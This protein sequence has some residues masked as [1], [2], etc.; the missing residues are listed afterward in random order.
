MTSLWGMWA[1]WLGLSNKARSKTNNKREIMSYK[2]ICFSLAPAMH[3][4][5][6]ISEA[7]SATHPGTG[8][9]W[10][11]SHAGHQS[12]SGGVLRPTAT[13]E[14]GPQVKHS[15]TPH[16]H[17]HIE[18]TGKGCPALLVWCFLWTVWGHI[19]DILNSFL[20]VF[21]P[22]SIQWDS[23]VA[24]AAS[25]GSADN[26]P[27]PPLLSSLLWGNSVLWEFT[28]TIYRKRKKKNE[29]HYTNGRFS[30]LFCSVSSLCKMHTE[31]H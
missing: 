28:S 30:L 21:F 20:A 24:L 31:D 23:S 14:A 3:A 5:L 25:L 2:R 8:L 26:F 1:S 12:S 10:A 16:G 13:P 19:Q 15:G 29:I 7:L 11:H 17:E 22:H 6:V 27:N 9:S 18:E 4:Q